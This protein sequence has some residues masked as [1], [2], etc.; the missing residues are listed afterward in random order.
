VN[1]DNQDDNDQYDA[2]RDEINNLK[3]KLEEAQSRI[4]YYEQWHETN[5][6]KL[7][8]ARKT[9][10]FFASVIKSG[11]RWSDQCQ[12]ALEAST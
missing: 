12:A 4:R 5:S 8:E 1:F 7:A 2:D 3:R 11:E 9:I 6:R 10:G